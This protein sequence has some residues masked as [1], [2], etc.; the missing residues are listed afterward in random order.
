MS[1][2]SEVATCPEEWPCKKIYLHLFICSVE[3]ALFRKRRSRE[4]TP[5]AVQL[6]P[7]MHWSGNIPGLAGQLLKLLP[8]KEQGE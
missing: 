7:G 8:R 4:K 5:V 2:F 3:E 1:P 6:I